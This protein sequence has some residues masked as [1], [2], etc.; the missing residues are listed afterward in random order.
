MAAGD[1]VVGEVGRRDRDRVVRA[2]PDD[3]GRA[4]LDAEPVAVAFFLIH[5]K[6]CHAFSNRFFVMAHIA[7]H[8]GFEKGLQP[9]SGGLRARR[10]SESGA[11]LLT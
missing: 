5:F 2:Q 10:V 9:Q 8:S 6:R 11:I 3:P 1:A 4:L 7:N